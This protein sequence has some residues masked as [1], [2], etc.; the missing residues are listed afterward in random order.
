MHDIQDLVNNED[1]TGLAERVRRGDIQPIELLEA[2]IQRIEKVEPQLNAVSER[3]YESARLAAQQ[4]KKGDG[5][6]AGVPTLIKDLFSPLQGATMS[7]GSL[8]M[9]EFRADADSEIVSR[10][11]KA[12]CVLVGTSTSPEFGTSYSTESTRFGATC[13]PWNTGHSA[14]GSSGGAAALVAARV[15]PFAHG[16]DGGGSLRV[17]ASCCGVFGLKPSRG[18]MPSGPMVGEGWAGMGTPHAITLSVRDSAALLDATAGMDLG[19]PYAAPVQ[20]LPYVNALQCDPRPLRIALVEQLGP[21]PTSPESL[22]A[23]REAARLC[24]SLGHHVDPV[25]LPVVLPE[26]LDHVFTIIGAST[27]NHVDMLGRMR[28]FD[29]QAQELEVRTRIILR[30]KGDVSGAQYTAA[31]EWIH[32]L[33]RQLAVF[34]QDYDVILSP[35]LTREP[36]RLG[37][38]V[39][40]DICTSLDELLELY[41]SYSPFTALF[42]ASGQPAMSVPLSWSA[43]GLPMGAHFAGRFGD[44]NTL[45]ALAAQLERAQPWRNRVP[46]VNACHP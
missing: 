14:G 12:G 35:V 41:H 34:M 4:L 11:R 10:L 6:F 2:V 27:R 15:V 23:V 29:V 17:P 5:V 25:S 31:V 43:R 16:N 37:E 1:A 32:A 20:P 18:L 39:L 9:G 19:A 42:N 36:V 7:N 30:D 46:S 22:T 33:G 3:L 13:N 28:G 38:L 40:E 45:L 21:W 8:S 24:E 44:E 26:F